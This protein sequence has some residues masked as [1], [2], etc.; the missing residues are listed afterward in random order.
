[1][2]RKVCA[3]IIFLL[4]ASTLFFAGEKTYVLMGTA[5][6]EDTRGVFVIDVT[7]PK[8]TAEV[9]YMNT[10][11]VPGIHVNGNC[12]YFGTTEMMDKFEYGEIVII[13]ISKIEN[14]KYTNSLKLMGGQPVWA[15]T[16]GNY[17]YLA[18]WHAGMY[19]LDGSDQANPK[20]LKT[21]YIADFNG[22]DGIR[23]IVRKGD[24]VYLAAATIVPE[25]VYDGTN[26][27]GIYTVDI[28]EHDNPKVVNFL[29]TGH[30][31]FI[32]IKVHENYLFTCTY[33]KGIE[34]F[35]ISDPKYPVPIHTRYYT[36][37]NPCCIY[38]HGKYGYVADEGHGLMVFDVSDP[39]DL[40][41]INIIDTPDK[42]GEEVIV[43]DNLLYLADGFAGL[44]I[45]D[46][47]NPEI[48]VL[49]G[50]HDTKGAMALS[51]EVIKK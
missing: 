49:I 31:G 25:L 14:P 21:L 44:G 46:I 27:I 2:K 30:L 48:P 41:L 16:E 24:Y 3:I 33:G 20:L 29:Y 50:E 6:P 10:M 42:F 11:H 19:L 45:Y 35:D 37:P 39:T 34:V 40:E 32:D 36:N 13:D 9:F 1:M 26:K 15:V 22:D 38:I 4:L 17:L 28:S 18:G 51:I 8:N 47:S 43:F 12:V 23:D 7:D 5:G